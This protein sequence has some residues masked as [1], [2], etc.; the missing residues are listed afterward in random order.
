M[1][2]IWTDFRHTLGVLDRDSSHQLQYLLHKLEWNVRFKKISR[3]VS[4]WFLK[5]PSS[6][7]LDIIVWHFISYRLCVWSLH[8]LVL[9]HFPCSPMV[10]SFH[11]QWQFALE[12]VLCWFSFS[13]LA[14]SNLAVAVR[15]LS[16]FSCCHI[17]CCTCCCNCSAVLFYFILRN[18]CMSWTEVSYSE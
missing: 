9:N 15:D 17:F 14:D 6:L 11:F 18:V 16:V 7:I 5:L 4:P 8:M 1:S 12:A 10:M 2:R 13:I 3:V